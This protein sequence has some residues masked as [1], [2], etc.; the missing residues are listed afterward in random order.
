[1][2][3]NAIKPMNADSFAS[4]LA[5]V[6]SIADKQEKNIPITAKDV[7]F[8]DGWLKH[9]SALLG[10]VDKADDDWAEENLRIEEAKTAG[11]RS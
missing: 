5:H 4:L 9:L 1:M 10:T 8:R 6:K 7:Q 11:W 3:P 2:I